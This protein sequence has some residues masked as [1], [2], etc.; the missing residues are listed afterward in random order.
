[1]NS[2]N[3]N[4]EK[5]NLE[6]KKWTFIDND[7]LKGPFS[8]EELL[9]QYMSKSIA[10][11]DLILNIPEKKWMCVSE[12]SYIHDSKLK[13][14]NELKKLMTQQPVIQLEQIVNQVNT[15]SKP[16]LKTDTANKKSKLRTHR[17]SVVSLTVLGLMVL[18][19]FVSGVYVVYQKKVEQ[20]NELVKAQKAEQRLILEN[21]KIKKEQI[22]KQKALQAEK[23][24]IRQNFLKKQNELLLVISEQVS[25]LELR[26]GNNI[27]QKITIPKY[28]DKYFN[29]WEKSND[30]ISKEIKLLELNVSQNSDL[31]IQFE[32]LKDIH[33]LMENYA[34]SLNRELR[35]FFSSQKI[36]SK[37]N[38]EII[39]TKNILISKILDLKTKS[40]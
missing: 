31:S 22:L 19:L 1:M 16:D 6:N 37:A 18:V 34:N 27:K 29:E 14:K 28:W 3:K 21:E 32:Q 33:L 5:T 10:D 24:K 30:M 15:L 7:S 4:D 35:L 8:D 11:D 9:Q 12:I 26:F 39:E 38:Q 25:I 13:H 20:Q 2:I 40:E 36:N 23:N 17:K